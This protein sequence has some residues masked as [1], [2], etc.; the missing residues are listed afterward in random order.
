[1]ENVPAITSRGLDVVLG[2]MAALGYHARWGGLRAGEVGAP[3][4]RERWFCVCWLADA[5]RYRHR[6]AHKQPEQD[7]PNGGAAQRWRQAQ[8][9]AS[10][11]AMADPNQQRGGSGLDRQTAVRECPENSGGR[12][13]QPPTNAGATQRLMGR[14]SD[15]FPARL[16]GHRWPAPPGPQH[17]WEAA[18]VRPRQPYDRNRL[19]ALGNAVV[20]QCGEVIG[21]W[22]ATELVTL[23]VR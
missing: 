9:H 21:R 7:S 5:D 6:R 17:P 16:D 3:H 12:H 1:M 18:R 22:I 11:G 19:K 10:V 15:G 13:P 14:G 2:T 8:N 23:P 20:P 4:R